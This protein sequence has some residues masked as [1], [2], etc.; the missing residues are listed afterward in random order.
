MVAH[1]HAFDYDAFDYL[2]FACL[3]GVVQLVPLFHE[4]V[5]RWP[6]HGVHES[7]RIS[8]TFVAVEQQG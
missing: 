2:C 3:E 4:P 1:A 8:F 5:F 6:F 7:Y